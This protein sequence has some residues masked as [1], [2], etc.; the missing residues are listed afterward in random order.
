[1]TELP[2]IDTE[3]LLLRPPRMEDFPDWAATMSDPETTRFIG[4]VQTPSEAWRGLMTVAGAWSL[5]G[6]SFFSVIE[7]ASGR[8][9]GR[10]GPW[11]P[12]GWPGTEV[13]WTLSRAYHGRGYALEAATAAIDFA[14]DRLGWSE[15]IHTI[16]PLNVASQNLARRLGAERIGP[17]ALPPPYQQSR[18]DIW[19]QSKAQWGARRVHSGNRIAQPS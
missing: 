14:F 15:V 16:D 11:A 8:W 9:V 1:M 17:G 3:R 2:Q 5:T 4:G 19:A 6:V 10:V 18:V 13:G 7:R 12:E